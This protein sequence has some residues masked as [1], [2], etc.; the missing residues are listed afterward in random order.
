M[1]FLRILADSVDS[2]GFEGHS[3]GFKGGVSKGV[4]G[5]CVQEGSRGVWWILVDSNGF[6]RD[7]GGFGG[8]WWIRGTFKGVQGGCVQRVPDSVPSTTR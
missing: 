4:Q 2:G 7:F 1:D 3:R 5:G 6:L 8:F